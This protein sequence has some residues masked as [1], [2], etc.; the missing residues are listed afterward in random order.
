MLRPLEGALQGFAFGD[1]HAIQFGEELN[2]VIV[3]CP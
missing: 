3:P 2:K 1:Q